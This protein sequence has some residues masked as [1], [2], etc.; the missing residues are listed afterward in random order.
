MATTGVGAVAALAGC[1]DSVTGSGGT[2]TPNPESD[3]DGTET[4]NPESTTDATETPNP[5][6][7]FR[8]QWYRNHTTTFAP[9]TAAEKWTW[10]EHGVDVTV[11][12]SEGSKSAAKAV[13]SGK[14]QFGMGGFG[15]VLQLIENGAP[16]T[17][18][19]VGMDPFGGVVSMAE[20][21]ITSWKD[22]E[23]KTVGQYP[24]GSTGP[25]A[26]AAMREKGVDLS[27]VSFQNVQP[28]SALKLL[29]NGKLDG[30]IR[31]TPQG[32]AKLAVDGHDANILRS[33]KVLNHLGVAVY[34]RDKVVEN[35]PDMVSNVVGGWL[36]GIKMWATDYDKVI[37]AH[38]KLVTKESSRPWNEKFHER[39]VG[40]MYAAYAPSEGTKP[41][42]GKG[43]VPKQRM[44]TTVDVFRDAGLLDE[45]HSAGDLYTNEFVED[46]HDLAV[47]TRE[48][49]VEALKDYDVGP[50][51]V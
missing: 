13:A 17:I 15:A 18:I 44:Q 1:L 23:G 21:G 45:D 11:K 47:E 14:N 30:M 8:F 26:K 4:P 22:L 24:W 39:L 41:D 9:L 3:G 7:S 19:G 12:E 20:T 40:P 38:K 5:K 16:L 43:Y 28:G 34:A 37:A 49:L 29:V 35:E 48:A 46:N 51:Y 2:E 36:D 25:V 6:T 27:K 50:D 32:K 31:Y 33:V 10:P 42:H